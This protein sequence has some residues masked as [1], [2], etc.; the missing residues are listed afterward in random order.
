MIWG[1]WFELACH[2]RGACS[3]KRTFLW[4]LICLAGMTVRKELTGVTSIVR[5]LG[6]LERCYA[7]ILGLYHATSLN[8]DRLTT[9]W[10]E[11][12]LA[13]HPGILRVNGR[14]V[15]VGDA[16][17]VPKSGRKMPSVKKLHQESDSNTKPQFIFGH[18][19][20]AIAV[21]G[22]ALGSVFA[23]P[24]VCRIHEGLVFSNRCAKTLLDKMLLLIDSLAIN[25]AFYFV[26]DAAYAAGKVIRGLLAKGNHLVSRV[27]SNSVAYFPTVE[28]PKSVRRR[29]RP[30]KYGR[31]IK[32]RELLDGI[33][34]LEKALSPIYSEERVTIEFAVAD[35]LWRAAGVLVRFIAVRHPH[36][37]IIL[38]MC[39]DLTLAPIE[40]IRLYGLRFKIEVSFK[41]ALRTL[42]AYA[43]HFW[44]K[45]MTPL[46]RASGNQYLHRATESYRTAVR[47]KLAAY[48][49]HIQLG[50][51]AQGLLH[52]LAATVPEFIWRSFG[53]WLRTIRP[54]LAPSEQV[55][56]NALGNTLPEFLADC[57]KASIFTK[58]LF[59]NIDPARAEGSRLIA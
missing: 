38:L 36:R 16:I 33:V 49:C 6:L 30:R 44:M 19:C 27:K 31:K 46:R 40:I 37:G 58:F 55:T 47:R 11:V 34:P 24:L 29:G 43:Y 7:R 23:V 17:K 56:A 41:Q 12:V 26:A 52:I 50:L 3:R 48:H 9:L 20:Q 42:G 4:L 5:G 35:L 59:Q 53:S 54:G 57:G 39:T 8:L 21:L 1:H 10:K 32:V 25:E 2:L 15:L 14:I 13:R 45:A 22:R 51:I 18:S 28:L